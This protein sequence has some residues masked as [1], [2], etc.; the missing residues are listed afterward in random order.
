MTDP[1][2]QERLDRWAS[3]GW[4]EMEVGDVS[5]DIRLAADALDKAE[6]RIKELE[7]AR[8]FARRLA[9]L[10]YSFKA[11]PQGLAGQDPLMGVNVLD[12]ENLRA[13][14]GA[15]LSAFRESEK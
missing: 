7:E 2:L 6:R 10:A 3:T 4:T 13:L 15:V 8:G 5:A 12:V 14:S 9:L 1:T 11:Y